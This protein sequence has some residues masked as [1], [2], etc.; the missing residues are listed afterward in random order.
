MVFFAVL[1]VDF[2]VGRE[3][4]HRPRPDTGQLANK[5]AGCMGT[6]SKSSSEVPVIDH[7]HPTLD[8]LT[9][10]PW[11]ITPIPNPQTLSP[12]GIEP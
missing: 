3:K 10:Y 5:E 9:Q 12:Q 2:D 6:P 8:Y 11:T 7:S 4:H 1:T